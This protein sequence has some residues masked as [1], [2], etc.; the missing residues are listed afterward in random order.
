MSTIRKV[1][2]GSD[3][4]LIQKCN[5][6]NDSI[7]RNKTEQNTAQD[8]VSAYLTSQQKHIFTVSSLTAGVYHSPVCLTTD[9]YPSPL[10]VTTDIYHFTVV[11]SN[12]RLSTIVVHRNTFVIHRCP[13]TIDI[14]HSLL[15]TT[16]D[17]CHS[18][19]SLTTDLQL[20]L[21]VV[22][23]NSPFSFTVLPNYCHLLFT[24][25][26]TTNGY[27]SPLAPTIHVYN[28]LLPLTTNFYHSPLPLTTDVYHSPLRLTTDVYHSPLSTTTY[29]YHSPSP[30]NN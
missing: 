13:L 14:D 16:N 19:F 20:S 12:W 6:Y 9:N 23:S 3:L 26:L 4:E 24:S 17:V 18:P 30:S 7:E 29:V 21:D 15:S 25:P 27:H 2:R 22:L 5:P 11:R 8:L 28:S 10:P 1:T